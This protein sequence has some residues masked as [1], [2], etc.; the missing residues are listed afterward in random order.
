MQAD[1]HDKRLLA[2]F[3][4]RL[5][6]RREAVGLSQERLAEAARLHR[7][8]VNAIERGTVDAGIASITN[9]ALALGIEDTTIDY[10]TPDVVFTRIG[11]AIRA[12]APEIIY[13]RIGESLERLRLAHGLSREKLAGAVGVHRNTIERIECGATVAKAA[14][15]LRLYRHFGICRIR[16]Q[17]HC[18]PI[19]DIRCTI[20]GDTID[21][22]E[23]PVDH[24]IL[25]KGMRSPTTTNRGGKYA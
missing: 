1:D 6:E 8:S 19:A 21:C 5:R 14:T 2:V 13:R 7:N 3:G 16:R 25:G 24:A 17:G 23:K 9:M 20:H 18:E 12:E 4:R 22:M 10:E 15:L 11:P